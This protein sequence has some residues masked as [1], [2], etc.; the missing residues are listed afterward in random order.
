[1]G[2][3]EETWA[4]FQKHLDYTDEEMK[5]FREN[6]KNAA[7]IL[8]APDLM[9]KTI[10]VE[11]VESRGCN[12]QHKVGD[13]FYFDGPGNLLARLGP[14]R[15]CSGALGAV[16]MAVFT[17]SELLYLGVDPNKMINKRVGCPDVGVECGGWGHIVMEVRVE[18]RK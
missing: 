14:K 4:F 7:I 16:S 3:S 18:D 15:I 9:K 6:P 17:A 13:Q 12:A 1:M 11:V 10:I 5:I 8:K 2:V